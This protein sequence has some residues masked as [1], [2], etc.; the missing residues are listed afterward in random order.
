MVS[1]R[2]IEACGDRPLLDA[3]FPVSE[4]EGEGLEELWG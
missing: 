3:G 2:L 1:R 4:E